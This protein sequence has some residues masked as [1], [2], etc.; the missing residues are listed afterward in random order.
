MFVRD[1]LPELIPELE[2]GLR[3][4]ARPELAAKVADLV[5][6]DRCRCGDLFCATFYTAPQP[7]GAYGPGHETLALDTLNVDV[8]NGEMV[9]VEILYR[10]EIRDKLA[11]VL[12]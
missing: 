8:L 10:D 11:A 12:P 7:I 2:D 6:I 9:C 5:I 1:V 4:D 3:A